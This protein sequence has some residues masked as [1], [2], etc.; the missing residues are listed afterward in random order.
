MSTH[1]LLVDPAWLDQ[2]RDDENLRILDATTFLE[3]SEDDGDH[4]VTSGA[5]AYEK[6]HIPGAVHADLL[7]DFSDTE[8]PVPFTV[9]DSETFAERI[10]RLG[11]GP[12]THVV[13]YDQGPTMWAARLWWNLRLEGFDDVS[14][15]DG[16]LPAWK[17]AGLPTTNGR[18]SCPPMRFEAHRR[19]ELYADKDAVLEALGDESVLLVNALDEPTFRGERQTYARAGHIPGSVNVP[20]EGLLD[21]HGRVRD[22]EQVR[23]AFASVGALDQD[24]KPVTYCGGGI[25]ASF[26]AFDLARLGREDVAVYDGSMNE[27]AADESLPLETS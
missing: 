2:R 16:G 4:R 27:W 20:F 14:V 5:Q 9:L 23:E 15:L 24:K 22:A 11:V 7:Q 8:A 17:E 10:G 19:P 13:V 12:G 3:L 18:D 26:V 6:E 1:P 25:A 21:Q